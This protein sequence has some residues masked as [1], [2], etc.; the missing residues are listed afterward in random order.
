MNSA[1]VS[2]LLVLFLGGGLSRRLGGGDHHDHHHHAEHEGHNEDEVAHNDVDGDFEALE[3]SIGSVFAYPPD[4]TESTI[5][6]DGSDRND[7]L[8]RNANDASIATDVFDVSKATPT[9]LDD[10]TTK[11]CIEKEAF[12]EELKKD[13][14]LSCIH[15]SIEKCHYTYTTQFV[16]NTERVC[17]KV[18]EKRCSITYSQVPQNETLVHCYNPLVRACDKAEE[19]EEQCR[20]YR[21]TACTTQYV[22]RAPGQHVG[23][24]RCE[25]IPV[26]YCTRENCRM[27]PGPQECHDKVS[28][29]VIDQPEERCDL[30]P[31]SVCHHK[32]K[33]VPRLRPEPECVL[34]PQQVCDIKHV[35][36]RVERVPYTTLWC[37]GDDDIETGSDSL[38]QPPPV[39]EGYT[40]DVPSDPLELP[41]RTTTSLPVYTES[42]VVTADPEDFKPPPES[43]GDLIPADLEAAIREAVRS[44]VEAE[45]RKALM[46]QK[47]TEDAQRLEAGLL[48]AV[49]AAVR[50]VVAAS[51]WEQ[52]SRQQTSSSAQLE[53]ALRLALRL[54]VTQAVEERLRPGV[55]M[56]T[57]MKLE[58]E[59][60]EAGVRVAV[61]E[62]IRQRVAGKVRNLVPEVRP[63]I[64]EVSLP[65]PVASVRAAV[66]EAIR[67]VVTAA[68]EARTAGLTEVRRQTINTGLQSAVSTSLNRE[69]VAA[70]DGTSIQDIKLAVEV[71]VMEAVRAAVTSKTSPQASI[72]DSRQSLGLIQKL[73]NAVRTA[74][75]NQLSQRLVPAS[76]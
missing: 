31:N 60:I 52:T 57:V 23:D 62:A 10:G 63:V 17:D 66:A 55:V 7:S 25:H 38:A 72:E 4:Y 14:V 56:N 70:S 29:S 75:K 30:V 51:I 46:L 9:I 11:L 34:V 22:E 49:E 59:D 15:K 20:E 5:P 19:G 43:P 40:Y 3:S 41:P 68:L 48:E 26:N 45:L 35:N 8:G 1:L 27:V 53:A 76:P 42:A 64:T 44:S 12:R 47:A 36:T 54:A 74:V 69:L 2:V 37:Q 32:T 6:S 73:N 16:P 61:I 18:Y 21:E 39:T 58:M 33:L 67:S 13:P 71:G 24:T 28:V 65:V 50:E